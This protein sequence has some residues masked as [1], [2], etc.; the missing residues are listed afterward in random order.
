MPVAQGT[1]PLG[2]KLEGCVPVAQGTLPLGSKLEW[3]RAA[4]PAEHAPL[5]T[6][7]W[8][9]SWHENPRVPRP[10]LCWVLALLPGVEL[11]DPRLEVHMLPG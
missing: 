8:I 10:Q 6:F 3:A 11:E 5:Y 7:P 9:P 2:S 4:C 1:Q